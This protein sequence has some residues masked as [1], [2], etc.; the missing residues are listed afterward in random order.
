MPA[1]PPQPPPTP[2][3]PP[4]P[5]AAQT[6]LDWLA[7]LLG[8]RRGE[9]PLLGL[10]VGA[11][12]CLFTAYSIMKPLRDAVGMAFGKV[13]LAR[14][15]TGTLLLMVTATLV[16]GAA[17][18]LLRWKRFFIAA[19]GFWILGT[20]GFAAAFRMIP[21]ASAGWLG[22]AFFMSVSV[23]NLLSLSFLWSRLTD[24]CTPEQAK[25]LFPIIGLGVTLGGIVGAAALA[26]LP[27]WLARYGV[28]KQTL[29][30]L[31]APQTLLFVAAGL[32][33]GVLG[34]AVLLALRPDA[35]PVDDTHGYAVSPVDA[36]RGAVEALVL[37]GRST[38]L[39]RLC[40][41]LFLYATTGTILYFQQRDIISAAAT[42]A[43]ERARAS[44][45]I[46][47]YANIATITLQVLA[48]GRILRFIGV[49]A[50]LTI[51]PVTTALGIATLWFAPQLTPLIAVQVSR[52]ALHYALDR[53]AREVL[54]TVLSPG[55]R[56]KS[57]GL[58]DTFVYRL[59]D[60]ARGCRRGFQ[61]SGPAP[62]PYTPRR[63]RARCGACWGSPSVSV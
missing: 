53:P 41:Y 21:D 16:V 12:F 4:T 8:A 62:R 45:T 30:A 54:Y 42:T 52:R 9:L 2:G 35:R 37:V 14:L 47:L 43:S 31:F 6:P 17:V 18:S 40:L 58:I 23:F 19:Q 49:G 5:P 59:G 24:L 60:Q 26:K 33:L 1:P 48:A 57:K 61:P 13:G 7:A 38:Y 51:T 25:R 56:H 44:A 39:L 20:L 36:A 27:G 34:A 46:D 32:L 28:G 11:G 63:A 55:E 22:A 3:L 10:G 15:T 50:A 29:D